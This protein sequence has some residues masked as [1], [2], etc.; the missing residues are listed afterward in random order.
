MKKNDIIL[1]L[2]ILFMAGAA[3]LI[4]GLFADD[5]ELL[6][7]TIDGN[8]QG[9]YSLSQKRVIEIGD[10]NICE[11]LDGKVKM[12]NA[13]CPDQICVH[14]NAIEAD[15]ETIVCLPNRVTLTVHNTE[16]QPEVDVIVS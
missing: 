16:E 2:S 15:G 5:A 3:W 14:H 9:E 11:I 7:I 1:I 13:D 12:T 10:G 4:R 8:T 6:T